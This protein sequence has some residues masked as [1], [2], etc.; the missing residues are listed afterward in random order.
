MYNS[1]IVFHGVFHGKNESF[2]KKRTVKKTEN[3]QW[4]MK[5][6]EPERGVVSYTVLY[7]LKL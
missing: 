7:F 3:G 6:T 4:A 2:T 1:C 5:A